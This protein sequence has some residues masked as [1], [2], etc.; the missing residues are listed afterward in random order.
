MKL[1]HV[2]RKEPPES[3][4]PLIDVVFFLLVFFMLI[5]R[6]DATAPFDVTPA[7][8]LTGTDMPGGGVTISIASNGALALDGVAQPETALNQRI[9]HVISDDA[10]TLIRVNAHRNAAL[11][12]VLPLVARM[13]AAGA[14]DI[15]L[16]VTPVAP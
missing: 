15:V 5:G 6:M 13:E 16:V 3:I 10:T 12:A 2:P 4:L 14:R 7:I 11:S 9:L 1:T 8:A